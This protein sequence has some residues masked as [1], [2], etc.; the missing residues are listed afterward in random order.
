MRSA[1]LALLVLVAG[2]APRF[3]GVNERGGIVSFFVSNE[4]R[5]FKL[6]DEHCRQFGRYAQF[7]ALKDFG[8][9]AAFACVP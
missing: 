8:P 9:E 4:A 2:C 5:A 1:S 3:E 7:T 6:A